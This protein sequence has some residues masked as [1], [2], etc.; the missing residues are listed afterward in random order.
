MEEDILYYSP[1]VMFRGTPYTF[2]I[3]QVLIYLK[4]HTYFKY[5][6]SLRYKEAIPQ[7]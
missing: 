7:F 1:T 4:N 3:C 5:F 6:R 2:K